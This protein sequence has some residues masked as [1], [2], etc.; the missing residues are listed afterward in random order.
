MG[1]PLERRIEG[2]QAGATATIL[3]GIRST[4]FR[5][6]DSGGRHAAQGRNSAPAVVYL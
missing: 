5:A 1:E 2:Q 3:D 4:Q 6:E